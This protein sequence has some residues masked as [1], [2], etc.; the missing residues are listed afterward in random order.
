MLKCL[1]SVPCGT[2]PATS[3]PFHHGSPTHAIGCAAPKN[4]SLPGGVS[5]E[6]VLFKM[7]W[8]KGIQFA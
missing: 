4:I 7:G 6:V 5:F 3:T 8:G 1:L 2:K